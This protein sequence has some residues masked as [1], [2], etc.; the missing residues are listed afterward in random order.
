MNFWCMNLVANNNFETKSK[1]SQME[2]N[3]KAIIIARMMENKQ[4]F[5]HKSE[6]SPVNNGR[7]ITSL[8]AGELKNFRSPDLVFLEQICPDP[9]GDV[10]RI[11]FSFTYRRPRQMERSDF[12]ESQSVLRSK[13]MHSLE[14]LTAGSCSRG[15]LYIRIDLL[16]KMLDNFFKG[17]VPS[18]FETTIKREKG[19]RVGDNA[20]TSRLKDYRNEEEFLKSIKATIC[21]CGSF[22]TFGMA[23]AVIGPTLL[24]LGCVTNRPLNVMSW[25]FF[26]QALSA[27]FGSS[28]GGY[29]ADR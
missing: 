14:I 1:A 6:Y 18:I 11:N 24:E 12:S 13:W 26:S 19:S 8:P 28:L 17:D 29:L 3:N 16:R 5:V 9:N 4:W 21:Y 22:W 27:L 2:M 23:A 10:T 20:S 25:V 7:K 15:K